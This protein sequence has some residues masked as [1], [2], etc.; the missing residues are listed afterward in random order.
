MVKV[1]SSLGSICHYMVGERQTIELVMKI[2]YYPLLE[3]VVDTG[4]G[5]SDISPISETRVRLDATANNNNTIDTGRKTSCSS[6]QLGKAVV[7]SEIVGFIS[8]RYTY[9]SVCSSL[10]R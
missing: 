4:R 2:M 7:R 3:F 10:A 6:S 9:S 5:N 8:P 1:P